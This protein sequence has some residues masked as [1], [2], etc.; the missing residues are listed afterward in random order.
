MPEMQEYKCPN[1]G[2]HLVFDSQS[3]NMKCP[4]CDA[5]IDLETVK[6]LADED[7][8]SQEKDDWQQAPQIDDG[9]MQ[10]M[11]IYHCSSCGGEI[12]TDQTT[13]ATNC[14]FCDSPMVFLSQFSG[15]LKPD[16][17]VPFKLDKE[18]AKNGLKKH[19]AGKKLLPKAF[20]DEQIID[21]IKGVYVPFWLF[22]AKAD[23]Q[24]RY[25]ATRIRTYQNSRYIYTE[26]SHYAVRRH[27]QMGFANIP[28]D[29]STKVAEDLMES[30]EPYDLRA[31]VPFETA[32][33]SGF[34]AD[35]Y[36]I[37][38]PES[39]VRAKERLC[40]TA[41]AQM[42][43]TVIGYATVQQ[44][45]S[46]VHLYDGR[47]QYVLLPVWLLNT[48]YRNQKLTFAMNGQTGQ[49]VGNLPCDN[50]AFWLGFAKYM[51]IFA[52]IIGVI[53]FMMGGM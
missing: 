31:A 52:L 14:P 35:K 17:V 28:V 32:Y 40:Q 50:K 27:G 36:D 45:T 30:L 25:H 51:M 47:S 7:H 12:I 1:C 2:G 21:E 44:E 8:L 20:S 41:N 29:A 5:E 9:S 3:Q 18:M 48:T 37:A 11:M 53:F 49:F 19:M 10:N 26:T 38:M 15:D 6:A 24:A 13:G 33:L 4:Y 42:A 23:I 16:L 22:D 46:S 39:Q 43:A 34:L